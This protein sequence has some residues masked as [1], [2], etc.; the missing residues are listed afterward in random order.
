MRERV[1]SVGQQGLKLRLRVVQRLFH[2]LLLVQ[3]VG[4]FELHDLGH[5][6]VVA[7][8]SSRRAHHAEVVVLAEL[9]QR[10]VPGH[11]LVIIDGLNGG[12][13]VVFDRCGQLLLLGGKI[14]KEIRR[15]FFVFAVGIDAQEPAAH[16]GRIRVLVALK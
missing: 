11:R 7:A 4:D 2:R 15:G 13:P 8:G 3:G 1:G 9:R 12:R 14:S 6:G 16:R 5:A 10:L